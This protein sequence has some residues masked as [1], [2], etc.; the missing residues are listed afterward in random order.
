M[1][2]AFLLALTTAAMMVAACGSDKPAVS[3][4]PGADSTPDA[5]TAVE[6]T[7]AETDSQAVAGTT[8]APPVKRVE[9]SATAPRPAP[10]AAPAVTPVPVAAV[11]AVQPAAQP[12]AQP[13]PKPATSVPEVA[14][15]PPAADPDPLTGKPLYEAHCR[16]CHGVLGVPSTVMKTKFPK[17]MTFT[18]AFFVNR[19]ADSVVTVLMQ[20]KGEGMKTFKDKLSHAEMIAVAAYARSLAK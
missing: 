5:S 2:R 4:S 11:P 19:S 16:K 9:P 7:Q 12:R 13:A 3:G 1:T 8:K 14:V 6:Q 10:G 17:L 15:V 18:V 20:G